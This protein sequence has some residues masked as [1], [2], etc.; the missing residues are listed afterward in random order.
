MLFSPVDQNGK[1]DPHLYL[2]HVETGR[3]TV[4]PKVTEW[5]RRGHGGTAARKAKPFA[6]LVS[7]VILDSSSP[8]HF[9][10][11]LTVTS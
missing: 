4:Y 2:G 10:P 6:R 3:N 9:G 11:D 1:P 8:V 7:R 5:T